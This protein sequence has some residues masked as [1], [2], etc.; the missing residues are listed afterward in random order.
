MS[1]D[2]CFIGMP[3]SVGPVAI[4]G[5]W[6]AMLRA[7]IVGP[8]MAKYYEALVFS[9][10]RILNWRRKSV[11]WLPAWGNLL[12]ACRCN[13]GRCNCGCCKKWWK[14]CPGPRRH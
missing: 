8:P 9:V 1:N 13:C 11:V 4:L 14:D 5:L 12:V 7:A 6:A 10:P 3:S 2:A